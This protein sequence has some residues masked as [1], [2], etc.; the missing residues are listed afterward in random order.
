[1]RAI[2]DNN[3]AEV[4]VLDHAVHC[5]AHLDTADSVPERVT[6]D[7]VAVPDKREYAHFWQCE[8]RYRVLFMT[9]ARRSCSPASDA[10]ARQH[11]Q[12]LPTIIENEE[13]AVRANAAAERLRDA[14]T[15]YLET[16][17]MSQ[18]LDEALVQNLTLA[19]QRARGRASSILNKH[20][21]DG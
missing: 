21:D 15:T 18:A 19:N 10:E 6:I 1:V 14:L 9:G 2:C 16:E 11:S 13:K 20:R 3:L 4:R 17:G 5:I 12:S 7:L 8:T